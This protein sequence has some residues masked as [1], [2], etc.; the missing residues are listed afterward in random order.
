MTQTQ[1]RPIDLTPARRRPLPPAPVLIRIPAVAEA[2]AP[3]RRARRRRLRREVR[4]VACF[5][6]AALPLPLVLARS[7]GDT[8]PASAP[9][10]R[11]PALRAGVGGDRAGGELSPPVI[12]ISLEPIF[13]TPSRD[14]AESRVFL[15]GQLLPADTPEESSHGGH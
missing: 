9:A 10:P 1:E 6:L 2:H 13:S 7:G 5:L 3:K 11:G 12:S 14:L 15:S 4:V 8:R